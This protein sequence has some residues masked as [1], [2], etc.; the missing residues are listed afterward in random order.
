M[1]ANAPVARRCITAPGAPPAVGPYTHAVRH[2]D[3]LF[4]S[5]ALPLDPDTQGLVAGSLA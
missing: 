3:L 2:D 4:C 5:G 1:S